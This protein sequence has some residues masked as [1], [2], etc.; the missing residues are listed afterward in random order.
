MVCLFFYDIN[1]RLLSKF[2]LKFLSNIFIKGKVIRKI[3]GFYYVLDE[4][5]KNL[6][7][8]NIYE[9]KLRGMLKVKNDK[10]NC[11]IGDFVEFDKKEKIIEKIEKR[12][13]F[14]Y[15][16]LIANI[17]F[18]GILFSIKSPDF[19]FTNFQKMLLNANSQN[20][21]V[22][23]ILS[24]IDLV[25]QE[26]LE[27]FLNKF[28]KIFKDV[29][30][31]FPISTETRTGLSELK[32]YINKKS[33]VISGPSGAGKSTLINTLIG[34][35]V[36]TT[37]DIS[38]KTRKGRHTTIESRFFMT[39][40]YSYLI[41]TP[42][43]STLDFPKLKNK[44]ELEK[45]FPEFL[46]FIPNCKFRDCIHV[47]EPNCAIK[48]NVENGNISRERYDFYLYSLENIKF[49]KYT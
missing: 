20:I 18:I 7:E 24:K 31:I 11:I 1:F 12:Q 15:R 41:D 40:P 37:N 9:C 33:V 36:L 27:K 28:K 2:I 39:A 25:S 35:E 49:L 44:K 14:L 48:E 4:N 17:D 29:I 10:M 46:E 3:K 13:N 23:L 47:N 5:S 22:V 38:G 34:E 16:P 21:P 43:F 8:E 42:G 19:D 30:S 6:S 45:L 26:E 32:Q